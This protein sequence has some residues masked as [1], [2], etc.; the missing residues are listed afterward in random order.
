M[1]FTETWDSMPLGVSP[2]GP[3]WAVGSNPTSEIITSNTV[4]YSGTQSLKLLGDNNSQL[5]TYL[6]RATT[7]SFSFRF[8]AT[9]TSAYNGPLL[10]GDASPTSPI[11]AGLLY[12]SGYM[13]LYTNGWYDAF[14]V[15]LNTWHLFELDFDGVNGRARARMNGGAW[16]AYRSMSGSGLYVGQVNIS[17][18]GGYGGSDVFVD[19]MYSSLDRLFVSDFFHFF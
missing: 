18:Y 7:A 6:Q 2:A 3:F 11:Y 5:W 16:T 1:A 4:A 10:V 17:S 15:S 13:Y 9:G 8:R 12:Y 14:A 19:D